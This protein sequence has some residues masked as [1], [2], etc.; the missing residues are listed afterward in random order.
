M[1]ED[2]FECLIRRV[3]GHFFPHSIQPPAVIRANFYD[4]FEN[5]AVQ[6]LQYPE[7]R[8]TH[9][10]AAADHMEKAASDTRP[11]A[12]DVPPLPVIGAPGASSE[13]GPDR[14]EKG[15]RA[16]SVHPQLRV[17]SEPKLPVS[18]ETDPAGRDH[19]ERQVTRHEADP[20]RQPAVSLTA[21]TGEQPGEPHGKSNSEMPSTAVGRQLRATAEKSGTGVT[22]IDKPGSAPAPPHRVEPMPQVAVTPAAPPPSR[23]LRPPKAPG[24]NRISIGKVVVD[25]VPAVESGHR[26]PPARI[27]RVRTPKQSL[28]HLSRQTAKTGFGL[29]QM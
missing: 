14:V 21:E 6:P 7:S 2:Y 11:P 12:S 15:D 19:R 18:T 29:G 26:K 8:A 23:R 10:P 13:T 5:T 28:N 3:S 27:R 24:A 22:S 16:F 25:V 4:P 20:V 1:M 17:R 9:T